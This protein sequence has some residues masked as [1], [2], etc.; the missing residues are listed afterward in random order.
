MLRL[1][2]IRFE[3]DWSNLGARP[4]IDFTWNPKYNKELEI[5]YIDLWRVYNLLLQLGNLYMVIF[6]GKN[7][8]KLRTIHFWFKDKFIDMFYLSLLE[9]EAKLDCKIKEFWADE[10][11]KFFS[12]EPKIF[13]KK[14]D[15]NI[16]YAILYL[17][18]KND[19]TKQRLKILVIIKNLLLINNN[20]SNNFWIEVIKIF[21]YF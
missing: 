21:N 13:Y 18:K 5:I 4:R 8:T 1:P 9:L 12:I 7:T 20:I 10:G 2:Y 3:T 6:I 16:K 15:I 19:L 17:H 11:D 14:Q